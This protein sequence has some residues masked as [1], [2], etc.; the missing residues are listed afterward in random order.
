MKNTLEQSILDCW[1][2]NASPW[3][4]A[5]ADEQIA[6]RIQVTN[7]AIVDALLALSPTSAL[8]IGCGEGWLTDALEQHG[9]T[10]L[11][12]D[13]V[14]ALLEYARQHRRGRF[15]QLDYDALATHAGRFDVAVCNFSLI[16]QA[17]SETV[18][19]AVTGLLK[20]GGYFVV[21]TLH[22]MSA[23]GSEPYQ[24]G[25]RQGS[26]HGFDSS[27][28]NPAP[29]YFRTIE[30][31]LALFHEKQLDIVST[32]EPLHPETG[33]PVSIIFTTRNKQ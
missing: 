33:K 19:H 10:T 12:V 5:I 27:F 9:I 11:G 17:S 26:W 1:H 14:P 23:N 20:P 22:P 25:W 6:S 24:D 15:L 13:A 30:S 31:W 29:W 16:G 21:Q 3:I 4:T 28:R 18:M 7:K 8:D 2:E 32:V